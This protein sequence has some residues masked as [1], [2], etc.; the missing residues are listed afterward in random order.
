M[1]NAVKHLVRIVRIT[2]P[3]GA[4]K[5]LHY[6]QHDVLIGVRLFV[7]NKLNKLFLVLHH[8]IEQLAGAV[9]LRL[10]GA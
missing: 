1:L 9:Q 2:N 4:S 8:V 10:Y 3:S 6:V 5:M 7:V